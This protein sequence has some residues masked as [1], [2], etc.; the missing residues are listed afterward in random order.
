[1]AISAILTYSKVH[2]P[3]SNP[4]RFVR[5]TSKKTCRRWKYCID[6]ATA[7]TGASIPLKPMKKTWNF[8]PPFRTCRCIRIF[9]I[10][11]I[12]RQFQKWHELSDMRP[13][14]HKEPYV[15]YYRYRC[16]FNSFW[17]CHVAKDF[18]RKF[19][20]K[21]HASFP[22]W[23]G[24]PWAPKC[25]KCGIGIKDRICEKYELTKQAIQ[26]Q[27]I[28]P[29]KTY[30]SICAHACKAKRMNKCDTERNI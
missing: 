12:R 27:T 9:S 6:Q 23:F 30:F 10:K 22:L 2:A 28:H 13:K 4:Y 8:P 29:R 21:N 16:Y 25:A 1:M 15:F 26:I 14:S 17:E 19:G 7:P 24:R 18:P 5:C 3:C 11:Y 20:M